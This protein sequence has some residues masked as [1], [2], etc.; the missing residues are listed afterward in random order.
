LRG[1]NPLTA[2]VPGVDNAVGSTPG[3]GVVRVERI[4]AH[5][6]L[7]AVARITHV[8]DGAERADPHGIGVRRK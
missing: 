5:G 6:A 8:V 1:P 2:N 7:Q 3:V 4:G